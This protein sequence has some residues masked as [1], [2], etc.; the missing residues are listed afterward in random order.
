MFFTKLYWNQSN[1]EMN[2]VVWFKDLISQH[3]KTIKRSEASYHS[4]KLAYSSELCHG[5]YLLN[6]NFRKVSMKVTSI[7]YLGG[8]WKTEKDVSDL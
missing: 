4:E 7:S 8:T 3:N 2:E 6:R 1:F 5:F